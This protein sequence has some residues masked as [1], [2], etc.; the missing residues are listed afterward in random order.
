MT[1]RDASTTPRCPLCGRPMRR[2]LDGWYCDDCDQDE[3]R[4]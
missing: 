2:D 4:R 1:I 3:E